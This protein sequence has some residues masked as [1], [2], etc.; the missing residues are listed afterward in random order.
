MNPYIIQKPIITEK[1]LMLASTQNTYTFQVDRGSS[2]QQIK[3]AVEELFSVNV[4]SVNTIFGHRS[5]KKTGRKR[6]S[7]SVAKTKKALIKLK[8]GQT[9]ALFDLYTNSEAPATA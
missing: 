5:S 4:L 3:Q 1:S 2:K 9:I 8:A 7:S 6:L